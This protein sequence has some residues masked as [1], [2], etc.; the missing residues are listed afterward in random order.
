MNNMFRHT[1]LPA[2]LLAL[3]GATPLAALGAQELDLKLG[4]AA[5]TQFGRIEK[6]RVLDILNDYNKNWMQNAGA[7]VNLGARIDEH[8]DAAFGIGVVGTHLAR[9]SRNQVQYWY[10]FWAAY[11]SEARVTRSGAGFTDG[12]AFRITFGNFGY[13]YNPDTKNLG[14][15]LLR[16]YVYPGD[17]VSGFG[18]VFGVLARYEAGNLAN[19]FIVKS[20]NEE[21]P[22]YDFSVANILTWRA[23]P[24]VELGA[25]VNF[26]RLIP[27]DNDLTRPGRDCPFTD[28]EQCFIIDPESGDTLTGA[29]A[30]TKLMARLRIDPKPLFGLSSLFG[31]AFGPSDLVFYSEAALLGLKD[32]PV[33]Y[34]D[35][36]RRIPVMA[37]F[38]LPVLGWLDYLSVEVEWYGSRNFSDVYYTS[39]T[40]SWIPRTDGPAL[41]ANT[42]RDDWKWSF[43]ASKV[44][45]GNLQLSGQVASDHLRPGGS[46]HSPSGVEALNEWSNWYWN[47][48]LAYFF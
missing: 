29:I 43:N 15:Y 42:A 22:L 7:Q 24:G 38:N 31:R 47:A 41:N 27:G 36:W 10:P 9:G 13:G 12:S 3:L 2:A 11:V 48:K 35:V 40:A 33:H 19:D 5:W 6:S 46:N 14:Q 45:F 17:L 44:L 1:M 34:E 26:Y 18:N 28:G 20:E 39:E 16:G 21:R 8:W 30:G 37:G 4:G 25:G 32:Y 23:T